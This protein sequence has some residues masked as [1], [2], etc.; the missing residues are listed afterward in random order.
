[1]QSAVADLELLLAAS[2]DLLASEDS[3]AERLKVWGAERDAVFAH[4][5]E[6]IPRLQA[7]DELTSC[8]LRELV[9]LDTEICSRAIEQQGRLARQ[10]AAARLVRQRLPN[11]SFRTPR[12]LQRVI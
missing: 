7:T 4:L 3:D 10:I 1:V 11:D 6:Q 12:L 5:K 9:A 2:R 8:L